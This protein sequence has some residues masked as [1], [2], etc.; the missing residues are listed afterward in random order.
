[1]S[2]RA[3]FC[4]VCMMIWLAGGLVFGGILIALFVLVVPV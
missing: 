3:I 1:M 4:F 2:T